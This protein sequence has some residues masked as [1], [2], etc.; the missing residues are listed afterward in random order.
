MIGVNTALSVLQTHNRTIPDRTMLGGVVVSPDT[1]TQ[2]EFLVY[3]CG[4]R[5]GYQLHAH[6]YTYIIAHSTAHNSR[7]HTISR[8]EP[9]G[10]SP[11]G[12][13]YLLLTPV[14]VM[15]TVQFCV[16]HN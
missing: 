5:L 8:H 10:S 2:T 7:S 3:C 6:A 1:H 9:Q 13:D 16:L 14:Y 11:F 12:T 4:K 15:W